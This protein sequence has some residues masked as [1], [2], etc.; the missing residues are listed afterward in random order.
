MKLRVHRA[1]LV[2]GS[3][4][5]AIGCGT[6][7]S[8]SRVR[9]TGSVG[10]EGLQAAFQAEGRALS[11]GDADAIALFID[12]PSRWNQSAA[13][14]VRDYLDPNVPADRWVKEASTHV[15]ELRAVY[16][17]MQTA[18]FAIGD[19]G[20]KTTCEELVENYRAKLD[21]VTA[22]HNAVA[23]G[24]QEGEQQAQHA[25]S[26][27]SAE[28]HRLASAFLDRLRPYVDSQTLVSEMTKR[29]KAVG[30]L[31]KPK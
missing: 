18:T 11:A 5:A 6:P 27:A 10:Q 21:S 7:P 28:G 17:E 15:S 19:P 31:M 23:R 9:P 24:D 8:S 22:L 14:L 26:T 13:P 20:I 16:L 25:L 12:L 1:T 30:E 29:G 2:T 3:L 4:I